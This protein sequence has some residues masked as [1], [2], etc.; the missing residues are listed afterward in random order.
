MLNFTSIE[1][2]HKIL[3]TNFNWRVFYQ[4]EH[5]QPLR[6]KHFEKKVL[7]NTT[8]KGRDF[9]VFVTTPLLT[10]LPL[11][12]PFFSKFRCMFEPRLVNCV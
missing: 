4:L 7:L 2:L 6:A 3:Q 8:G 10:T 5:I 1:R 11:V 12:T 9:S